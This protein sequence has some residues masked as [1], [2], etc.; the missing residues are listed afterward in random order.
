M[1]RRFVGAS[2]ESR[3]RIVDAISGQHHLTLDQ[4]PPPVAFREEIIAQCGLT[5]DRRLQRAR[6][7]VDH[8]YLERCLPAQDI[9]GA[10]GVLHA[11]QLHH[12]AVCALLLDDR[13]GNA[14]LVDPVSQDGD[15]LQ[16]RAVLDPLLR[17]GL[18]AGGQLELVARIGAVEREIGEGA[19]DLGVCLVAFRRGAEAN[20]DVLTFT[21]DTRILHLLFAQQR[22]DVGQITIGGLVERRL[23]VDLLQKIDAAAEVQAKVHRQGAD[24]RQP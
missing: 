3:L 24:R 17:L 7:V 12:H 11:G 9:L 18:E 14:E 10:C 16:D 19:V 6:I 5:A 1:H 22:A 4:E 20:D 15:V 8:S 21:C 13:L 2:V 23:H